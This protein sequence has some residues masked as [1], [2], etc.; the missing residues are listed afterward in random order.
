[1]TLPGPIGIPLV[2]NQRFTALPPGDAF[3]HF[4]EVFLFL[5]RG[6]GGHAREG[7]VFPAGR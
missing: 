6:A 2:L 4:L 3:H 5:R 7:H 1:M